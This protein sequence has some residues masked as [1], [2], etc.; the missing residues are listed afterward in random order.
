MRMPYPFARLGDSH[1][2]GIDFYTDARSACALRRGSLSNSQEADMAVLTIDLR[3][4]RT[5]E[6]LRKLASALLDAVSRTTGEPRENVYLVIHENHGSNFVH[7]GRH[8]PDVVPT[9][10]NI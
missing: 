3:N 10:S 5:D 9:S 8:L 1:R 6:Q 7:N 4:G 2:S